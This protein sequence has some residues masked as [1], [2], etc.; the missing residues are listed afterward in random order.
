VLLEFSA[1]YNSLQCLKNIII[2][3]KDD[4]LPYLKKKV[5]RK[6]DSLPYMKKK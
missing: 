6:D 2:V 1:P 3:K 5:I 4:S